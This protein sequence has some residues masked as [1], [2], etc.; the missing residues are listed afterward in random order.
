MKITEKRA[1]K[2]KKI[3]RGS[4]QKRFDSTLDLIHYLQQHMEETVRAI[5]IAINSLTKQNYFQI[6]KKETFGGGRPIIFIDQKT[7]EVKP[8][9]ITENSKQTNKYSFK[10][11]ID[12][13]IE[14]FEE[15]IATQ[16]K[17]IEEQNNKIVELTTMLKNIE[18]DKD[19]ITEIDKKLI[20]IEEEINQGS[21]KLSQAIENLKE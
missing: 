19:K 1:E 3:M 15:K 2:I 14:Q 21:Q 12:L 5:R 17:K 7:K 4:I 13:F 10:E 9:E 11:L 18:I 6:L 16:N 8:R 20:I